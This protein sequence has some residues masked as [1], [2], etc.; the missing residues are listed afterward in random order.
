MR[1]LI[2]EPNCEGQSHV[3]VN[4]GFI[5]REV[6]SDPTTLITFIGEPEH[7]RYCMEA[8]STTVSDKVEWHP[9]KSGVSDTEDLTEDVVDILKSK[10]VTKILALS[11]SPRIRWAEVR[12]QAG[13]DLPIQIVL[14]GELEMLNAGAN[15]SR[16]RPVRRS[17]R[18]KL[19]A[20]KMEVN[21][22]G[23]F[24]TWKYRT[25]IIRMSLSGR[26]RSSSRIRSPRTHL[27][28]LDARQQ[29]EEL[30]MQ[31]ISAVILSEHIFENA[32]PLLPEGLACELV[33]MPMPW[34][35]RPR[36]GSN[37]GARCDSVVTLGVY[38]HGGAF[39]DQLYDQLGSTL[40]GDM[41][42][43]GLRI[44]H[45]SMNVYGAIGVP[46]VECVHPNRIIPRPAMIR[47]G[48]SCDALVYPHLTD[49]YQLSCS[50][51]PF[52]ALWLGVPLLGLRAQPLETLSEICPAF[53]K[54]FDTLPSLLLYLREC[55]ADSTELKQ[56]KR[57]CEGSF[58]ELVRQLQGPAFNR[59]LTPA[60]GP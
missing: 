21:V 52:E 58:P 18:V 39:I 32:K 10:T 38:G 2:I 3:S 28:E 6:S 51:V 45:I 12:R 43:G 5:E 53:V 15:K 44:L 9:L 47:L 35:S 17:L 13:Y 36:Q 60:Y 25:A 14:H 23:I 59:P 30:R 34:S 27:P 57:E 20:L 55:L 41:E 7:L 56:R 40:D 22:F 37:T 33:T 49:E 29:L 16:D 19:L 1:T 24:N 26:I 11:Q 48:M 31:R 4:S 54:M 8:L 42:F 50:L 46:G